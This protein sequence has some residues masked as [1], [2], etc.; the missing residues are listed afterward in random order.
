[1]TRPRRGEVWLV[2]LGVPVGREQAGRRP[3]A[4][5]SADPLD[6]SRAVVVIAVPCTTTR[7]ELPSHVE[8]DPAGSGLDQVAYAKGEDVKSISDE[9]LITRLGHAPVEAMV[10]ITRV[11]R[12][13]LD[14]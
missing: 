10:D 7:R 8:L 5:V 14:A 4:I 2:D 13:L 12:F 3:A 1:M 6:A 11:L 9:R